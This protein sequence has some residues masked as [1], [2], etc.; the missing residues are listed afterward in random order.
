MRNIISKI[1]LEFLFRA[2]SGSA[3]KKLQP[4]IRK[5]VRERKC[6]PL[7]VLMFLKKGDLD[8]NVYVL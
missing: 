8:C 2:G 5:D 1:D 7:F 3:D 4:Y 6:H